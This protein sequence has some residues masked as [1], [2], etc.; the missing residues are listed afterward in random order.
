MDRDSKLLIWL[1]AIVLALAMIGIIVFTTM[2]IFR[3]GDGLT[4]QTKRSA[5]T[6]QTLASPED[7]AQQTA[8]NAQGVQAQ[9]G[10]N[11]Y[12][13]GYQAYQYPQGDPR[14]TTGPDPR[15][16]YGYSPGYSAQPVQ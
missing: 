9:Q 16:Q 3:I 14:N 13:P 8:Q 7:V 12:Y 4:G 11:G 2:W 1:A 6:Q 10:A 15:A 5:S